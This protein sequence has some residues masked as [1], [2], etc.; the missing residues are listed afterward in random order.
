MKLHILQSPQKAEVVHMNRALE[1]P[2]DGCD[3]HQS[4]RDQQRKGKYLQAVQH[5]L[6]EPNK[7]EEA[8]LR[9]PPTTSTLHSTAGKRSRAL[10]DASAIVLG[11]RPNS[12]RA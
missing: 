6:A 8:T 2:I 4:Q 11:Q 3:G 9:V 10:Q 7:H 12:V 5:P 1:R